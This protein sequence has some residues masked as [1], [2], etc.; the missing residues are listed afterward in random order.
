MLRVVKNFNVVDLILAR[1]EYSSFVLL[2]LWRAM[3]YLCNKILKIKSMKKK[4]AE[5][6]C[7]EGDGSAGGITVD[8]KIK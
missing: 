4:D 8:C 5:V 6:K 3:N 2:N 1:S 7:N